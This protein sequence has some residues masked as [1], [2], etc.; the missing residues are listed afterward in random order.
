MSFETFVSWQG[1][2]FE[3]K[4]NHL[5]LT[6]ANPENYYNIR[7][8]PGSVTW[9]LVIIEDLQEYL[10]FG[11]NLEMSKLKY[12]GYSEILTAG[13]TILFIFIMIIAMLIGGILINGILST[14]VETRIRESGIFRTLGARKIF[15]IKLIL[16]EG[17]FICL[18][19]TSL[20]I[21]FAM[22]GMNFVVIPV[23]SDVVRNYLSSPIPFIVSPM[24]ILGPLSIGVIV[25]LLVSL[26]TAIIVARMQIVQA[27]NP[28]RHEE[29][30]YK[31][32]KERRVNY[33]II[34]VGG[35]LAANG[36]FI[37]FAI[38]QMMFSMNIT[39]MLG[40]LFSVLL[41][42][43]IGLTFVGLGLMPVLQR[44]FVNVF[45]PFFKKIINIIRI[46]VF[47]YQRRNKT[48]VLM[49]S[50]SF[51]FIMFTTSMVAD[52][53]QNIATMEKFNTG[54]Q[55]VVYSEKLWGAVPTIDFQ[56]D[57][58]NIT[59]VENT[60]V[61]LAQTGTLNDI[62]EDTNKKFS[63]EVADYINYQSMACTIYPVDE[64][65]PDS[66]FAEYI[67]FSQGSMETP[68]PQLFV[69]GEDNLILAQ[70]VAENVGVQVG[71]KVRLTFTRG[72]ETTPVAFTLVEI[73]GKMPGCPRFK[74]SAMMG[75]SRGGVM[76]FHAEYLNYMALPSPAWVE[77]IFIK[78]QD[79]GGAVMDSIQKYI[80]NTYGGQ[81]GLSVRNVLNEIESESKTY[82]TVSFVFELILN[83][84]II[85][86]LFGLLSA[87]HSTILERRR[88]IAVVRTLGLRGRGVSSMFSLEAV[89]TFLSSS[90]AGTIVGY[91]SAYLLSS[92]MN[93]FTESPTTMGFPAATFFRTFAISLVFLLIGL[94]ILLRKTKK[95]KIIEIY[96][97]TL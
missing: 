50:V 33:K 11:Y 23:V 92:V 54:A 19:G 14:S 4:I 56:Y 97:E 40:V 83:I 48:T 8:F 81:Y 68:F 77:K 57:L 86:C 79:E 18:L 41:V 24:S 88:E 93:I 26:S 76:I 9:S 21:M 7:N 1:S 44:F 35:L 36:G 32:I 25:S 12:L 85:I 74:S 90:S 28:Y 71:D 42:F 60:L 47:R 17:L 2:W 49:F 69:E 30:L 58:M 89:I 22:L 84:T 29:V 46:T 64:Y 59:G 73:A 15:N 27:I 61:V 13:L 34:T 45:A 96:R 5:I 72:E 65:Y 82:N 87:T 52:L 75:S 91:V 38:P 16:Y 63:T 62:Y 78:V 51:A 67:G 55:L 3:G 94:G 31:I 43:L 70:A 80:I 53:Q 37:F 6:F 66:V 39:L 20:G 10:G 95:Q